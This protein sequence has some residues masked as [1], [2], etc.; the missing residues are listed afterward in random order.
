MRNQGPQKNDLSCRSRMAG[1][2]LPQQ[3]SWGTQEGKQPTKPVVAMA[4]AS[5]L[6]GSH[7]FLPL[8]HPEGIWGS[9][10][11]ILL[12][13]EVPSRLEMS[14]K[15]TS[16][17]FS[18]QKK[19]KCVLFFFKEIG[20][21]KKNILQTKISNE[22][23]HNVGGGMSS[24]WERKMNFPISFLGNQ[25]LSYLEAVATLKL[26]FLE[27]LGKLSY[28]F[29]EKSWQRTAWPSG[30]QCHHR[31]RKLKYKCCASN[32]CSQQW[33]ISSLPWH[34]PCLYFLPLTL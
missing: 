28:N 27:T 18:S 16:I 15:Q 6:W 3:P 9:T 7:L 5:P 2:L 17:P 24:G 23:N 12:K 29:F 26:G 31:Q 10:F 30:S 20:K 21:D 25:Y 19:K 22:K 8:L 14:Q 4:T 34:Q 13:G 32:S 11:Q 1:S 33:P